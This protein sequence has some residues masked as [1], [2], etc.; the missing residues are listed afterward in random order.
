MYSKYYEVWLQYQSK[1]TLLLSIFNKV[2]FVNIRKLH[3]L[4]QM[5]NT[6]ASYVMLNSAF[7]DIL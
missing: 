2:V 1:V 4:T 6:S 5:N 7:T 3:Q